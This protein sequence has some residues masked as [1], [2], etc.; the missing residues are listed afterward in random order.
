MKYRTSS[1]SSYTR[2]QQACLHPLHFSKMQM[3][4]YL[5]DL[6]SVSIGIFD[7]EFEDTQTRQQQVQ[8]LG[9]HKCFQSAYQRLFFH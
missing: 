2:F 4:Q 5:P 1:V 8:Q 6:R 7:G 9:V 3:A